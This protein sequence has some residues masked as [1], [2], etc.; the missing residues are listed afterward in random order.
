MYKSEFLTRRAA[1]GRSRF[2]ASGLLTSHWCFDGTCNP[3]VRACTGLLTSRRSRGRD[4]DSTRGGWASVG[5]S[6]SRGSRQTLRRNDI[7]V[8][9]SGLFVVQSVYSLVLHIYPGPVPTKTRST[10]T[11]RVCIESRFDPHAPFPGSL[12]RMLYTDCEGTNRA[13]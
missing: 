7:F 4:A 11:F 8:V 3:D 1:V 13:V 10:D 2:S 6:F 12:P 9:Q 5:S